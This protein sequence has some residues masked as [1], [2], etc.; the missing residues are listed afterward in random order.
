M[1]ETTPVACTLT[2]ADLAAQARRWEQLIAR[3]LTGRT[4]TADGL[5]LSFRPWAEDELRAL[6]AVETECCAWATW[7]VGRTAE[8]IVVDVH[9][10]AEGV[11]TLHTMFAS[12]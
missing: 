9:A 12:R 11:T 6:T 2:A 7:T 3:A 4:E 10:T 5:R 8:E 1:N